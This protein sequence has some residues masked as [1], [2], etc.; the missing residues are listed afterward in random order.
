MMNITFICL[1]SAA[2][3]RFYTSHWS[4]RIS[5][6]LWRERY[7]VITATQHAG[8]GLIFQDGQVWHINSFDDYWLMGIS[9][10]HCYH[11]GHDDIGFQH[12]L[13]FMLH[14]SH[15][16][17]KTRVTYYSPPYG[18]HECGHRN[19]VMPLLIIDF[20][21]S[22]WL[23]RRRFWRYYAAFSRRAASVI[24]QPPFTAGLYT[25]HAAHAHGHVVSQ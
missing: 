2:Y 21:I 5:R 19:A 17:I 3:C 11:A 4:V 24:P 16:S 20:H 13:T 10:Q 8:R 6:V 18:S 7:I 23:P 1:T 15:F 22:G 12:L 9:F 14:F 25:A